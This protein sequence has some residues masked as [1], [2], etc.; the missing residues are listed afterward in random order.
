MDTQLFPNLSGLPNVP[1]LKMHYFGKVASRGELIRLICVFT[2]IPLSQELVMDYERGW[3]Q[4]L[5]PKTPFGYLPCLEIDG[6]MYGESY[7]LMKYIAK[8]GGVYPASSD[9]ETLE[10]DSTM[11]FVEYSFNS[12]G[13]VFEERFVQAWMADKPVLDSPFS[14]EEQK[15]FDDKLL[16]SLAT[17]ENLLRVNNGLATSTS[18]TFGIAEISIFVFFDFVN[19]AFGSMIDLKKYPMLHQLSQQAKSNERIANYLSKRPDYLF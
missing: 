14:P 2:G 6:K 16:P 8:L 11:E 15:A 1:E 17:L 12:L 10:M 18:K 5:K 13:A 9:L 7:S 3:L 4:D 19:M